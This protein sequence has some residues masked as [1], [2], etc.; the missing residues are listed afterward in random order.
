LSDF[1]LLFIFVVDIDAYIIYYVM[2]CI[3]N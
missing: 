2:G 1:N 3:A